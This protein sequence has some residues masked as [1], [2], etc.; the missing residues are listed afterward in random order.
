MKDLEGKNVSLSSY[1]GKTVVLIFWE[2]SCPPC[3]W[4]SSQL[5]SIYQNL[6]KNKV[7]FIGVNLDTKKEN[8]LKAIKIDKTPWINISDFQGW[9]NEAV[10][11]YGVT[12]L[13]SHVIINDQGKIVGFPSTVWD[14]KSQLESHLN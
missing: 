9:T 4:E 3:R 2:S 8:A 1:R 7:V 6:E 10:L 11:F 12:E 14:F 5:V 13:P